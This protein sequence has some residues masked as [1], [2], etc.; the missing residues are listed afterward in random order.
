MLPALI[1]GKEAINVFSFPKPKRPKS[2]TSLAGRKVA[3]MLLSLSGYNLDDL[4]MLT[5]R[6]ESSTLTGGVFNFGAVTEVIIYRISHLSKILNP[7]VDK[8]SR[9][10]P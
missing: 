6:F 5:Q 10:H 4:A 9:S 3:S 1:K 8:S 2:H 7:T